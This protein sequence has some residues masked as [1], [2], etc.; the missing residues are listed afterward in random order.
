M[1]VA[2]LLSRSGHWR[3]SHFNRSPVRGSVDLPRMFLTLEQPQPANSHSQAVGPL[4]CDGYLAGTRG[5]WLG[6]HGRFHHGTAF[7]MVCRHGVRLAL[8][9]SWFIHGSFA[10]AR[11]ITRSG[12]LAAAA[13][14]IMARYSSWYARRGGS[15]KACVP[16]RFQ[17][18]G[19]PRLV[20]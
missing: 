14:F 20:V 11:L 6:G 12:S 5:S 9:T 8:F 1:P 18:G 7:V 13:R 2:P 4:A 10:P 3:S 17:R 15:A 16:H 19:S